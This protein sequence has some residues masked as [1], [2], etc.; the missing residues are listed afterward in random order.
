MAH[1]HPTIT[2]PAIARALREAKKQGCELIEIKPT[3]ELLI[4]LK[5]D[6]TVPNTATHPDRLLDLS[7][8]D[9][10]YDIGM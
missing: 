2:Q 10:D 9:F 4:Y 5:P 8:D 1:R 7:K 6:I 3:G